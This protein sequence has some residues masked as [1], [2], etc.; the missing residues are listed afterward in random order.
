M[1][2]G[3]MQRHCKQCARGVFHARDST[4]AVGRGCT[5]GHH[6]NS[7]HH[8]LR[9]EVQ[10]DL[11]ALL[12]LHEQPQRATTDAIADKDVELLIVPGAEHVFI[13]CLA[14]VRK[15]CWDFLADSSPEAYVALNK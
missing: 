2:A 13:D 4:R 3:R 15:R 1:S 9:H 10:V 14:Y 5:A 7:L 6:V 12:R 11:V 8:D